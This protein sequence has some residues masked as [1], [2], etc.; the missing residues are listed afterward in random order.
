[1]ATTRCTTGPIPF[2][3]TYRLDGTP[4]AGCRLTASGAVPDHLLPRMAGRLVAQAARRDIHRDLARLRDLLEEGVAEP[5]GSGV[6]G[7]RSA[8]GA[9]QGCYQP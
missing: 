4:G 2:V 7:R 1:M 3:A 9:L 6:H 5:A 8:V